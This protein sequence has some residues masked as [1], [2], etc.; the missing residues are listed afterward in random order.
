MPKTWILLMIN[1]WAI[2]IAQIIRI[3]RKLLCCGL[4]QNVCDSTQ[5]QANSRDEGIDNIS[6]NSLEI[7][8]THLC[9]DDYSAY[10]YYK[11]SKHHLRQKRKHLQWKQKTQLLHYLAWFNRKTILLYLQLRQHLLLECLSIKNHST[12]SSL[13]GGSISMQ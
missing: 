1:P 2:L 5:I 9:T 8:S 6:N 3:S 7:V 13:L 12:L 10:K 4:F 11:I